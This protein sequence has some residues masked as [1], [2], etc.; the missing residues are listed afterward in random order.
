[1]AYLK[2]W[3]TDFSLGQPLFGGLLGLESLPKRFDWSEPLGILYSQGDSLHNI[4]A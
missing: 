1:M 2:R 3:L 4:Q